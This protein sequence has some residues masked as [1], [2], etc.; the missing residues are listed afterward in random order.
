MYSKWREEHGEVLQLSGGS[1]TSGAG[2]MCSYCG[3][4]MM[5]SGTSGIASF[6]NDTLTIVINNYKSTPGV[7][8]YKNNELVVLDSKLTITEGT[9]LDTTKIILEI[10]TSQ[11]I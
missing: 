8:I 7:S 10:Q 9:Q 5:T 2:D 11:I 6:A 3:A 4:S 1:G